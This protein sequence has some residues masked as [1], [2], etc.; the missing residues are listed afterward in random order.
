MPTSQLP[1]RYQT[2]FINAWR[3]YLKAAHVV[4]GEGW[5][6]I[7]DKLHQLDSPASYLGALFMLLSQNTDVANNSRR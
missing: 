4:Q 1:G 5:N 6:D 7:K 3:A 2:D